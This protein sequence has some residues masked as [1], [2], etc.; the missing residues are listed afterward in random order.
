MLTQLMGSLVF[1]VGLVM[2]VIST[3][4][5][6]VTVSTIGDVERALLFVAGVATII[7]GYGM[8]RGMRI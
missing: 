2:V 3:L 8:V 5:T 7:I 4:A 6:V 1:L